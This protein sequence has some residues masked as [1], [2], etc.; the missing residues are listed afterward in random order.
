MEKFSVKCYDLNRAGLYADDKTNQMID[1]VWMNRF[2]HGNGTSL[3]ETLVVLFKIL[4]ST[5]VCY[6]KTQ[7]DKHTDRI[8]VRVKETK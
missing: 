8:N 7:K 1:S 3:N 6:T 4:F 5:N 2:V